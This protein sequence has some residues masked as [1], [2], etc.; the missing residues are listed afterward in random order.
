MGPKK[1]LLL[2]LAAILHEIGYYV[3]SK[4]HLLSTYDLI[5]NS[6]IYG[7]TQEEVNLIGIIAS[8]CEFSVPDYD[9]HEYQRLTEKNRLFVDKLVAILRLANALDRSQNQKLQSL[10]VRLKEEILTLTGVSDEDMHLEQWAFEECAPFFEEV[11][12][13]KP[14]FI[15]K[16]L[17]F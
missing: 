10:T 6:D 5:K 9:D 12:G 4:N 17:M 8:Y 13:I 11:F 15:M 14:Q 3:N 1:R 16:T 2:E 7:M